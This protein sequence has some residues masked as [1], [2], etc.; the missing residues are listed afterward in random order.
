M[1]WV[2]R[3]AGGAAIVGGAGAGR[4]APLRRCAA[5][6]VRGGRPPP[7]G[8]RADRRAPRTP[9]QAARPRPLT[10]SAARPLLL[11]ARGA[12]AA[13]A[14]S[15]RSGGGAPAAAALAA[16][17][18]VAALQPRRG[19]A[20]ARAA[21]GGAGG[22]GG[23]AGS[24]GALISGAL[25]ALWAGLMGAPAACTRRARRTCRGAKPPSVEARAPP[26]RP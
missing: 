14:A 18:R 21:D 11:R 5:P 9:L 3:D 22:G 8:R 17:A 7:A 13:A 10:R 2:R 4:R 15:D 23:D 16:P 24:S 26:L 25:L 12:A 1:R 19:A 20:V 6:G